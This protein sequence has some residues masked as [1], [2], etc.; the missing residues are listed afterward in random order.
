MGRRIHPAK[1]TLILLSYLV[2]ATAVIVSLGLFARGDVVQAAVGF[3]LAT[4][5]YLAAARES[6]R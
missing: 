1:L 6:K 2:S 3:F 5:L 4:V